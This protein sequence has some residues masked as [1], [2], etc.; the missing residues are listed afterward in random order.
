[1]DSVSKR[2]IF[3]QVAPLSSVGLYRDHLIW[4]EPA[5]DTVANAGGFCVAILRPGLG[6]NC[7]LLFGIRLFA[8]VAFFSLS[9]YIFA[10][11]IMNLKD[12]VSFWKR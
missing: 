6:P 12:C 1:M 2:T 3:R 9:F 7:L 5:V 11:P 10:R 4:G 8:T